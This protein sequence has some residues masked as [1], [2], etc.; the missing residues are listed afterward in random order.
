MATPAWAVALTALC[1]VALAPP[2][3]GFYLPG[4]APN[5]FEKVRLASAP[6]PPPA[7]HLS[8]LPFHLF[9]GEISFSP[10]L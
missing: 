1:L 10:S 2:A 9:A 5:D 6:R 7:L 3:A 4:V 8:R